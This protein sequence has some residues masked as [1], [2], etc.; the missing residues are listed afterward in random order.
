MIG[1]NLCYLWITL[2]FLTS[3]GYREGVII[4]ERAAFVTFSG[5]TVGATVKIDESDF[6]ELFDEEKGLTS[7]SD[8]GEKE[9]RLSSKHYRLT[10]GKHRILVKRNGVI[11]VDREVLLG[12]GITRE[13]L[14]P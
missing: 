5:N 10:P 6:F 13:V 14:L 8:T 11:I 9:K 12:D 1:K 7:F 2:L 3:C 4:A